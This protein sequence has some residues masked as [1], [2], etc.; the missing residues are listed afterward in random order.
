M[1]KLLVIFNPHFEFLA[2]I[3][4]VL[5]RAISLN[6]LVQLGIF[7]QFFT[8]CHFLSTSPLSKRLNI[9]N[10]HFFSFYR[11]RVYT[12]ITEV[13]GGDTVCTYMYCIM[14]NCKGLKMPTCSPIL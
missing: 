8:G 13:S 9:A 5:L 11:L 12:G 10:R 4:S 7:C 1:N 2:I 6:L 14:Y 3:H